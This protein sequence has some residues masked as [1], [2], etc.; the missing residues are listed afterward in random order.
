MG[1]G[2]EMTRVRSERVVL[3]RMFLLTSIVLHRSNPGPHDRG[4]SWEGLTQTH[5]AVPPTQKARGSGSPRVGGSIASFSSKSPTIM[6]PFQILSRGQR[7]S[8]EEIWQ[9]LGPNECC[10]DKCFAETKRYSTI[11]PNGTTGP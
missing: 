3:S 2:T 9:D 4:S 6:S 11:A 5:P 7:K 1:H 10:L 8:K